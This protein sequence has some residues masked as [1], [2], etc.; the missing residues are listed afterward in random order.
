MPLANIK[1]LESV[2]FQGI[3]KLKCGKQRRF[4]AVFN[5]FRN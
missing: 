1:H 4:I 3:A 2:P 5:S